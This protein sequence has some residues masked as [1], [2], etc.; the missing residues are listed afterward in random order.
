MHKRPRKEKLESLPKIRKRLFKIWSE[1]CRERANH[2]CEYCGR[3][4]GDLNENGKPLVKVDAHHLQSRKIS[5][6]PLK[7]DLR[8]SVCV[9]PLHH[10]FSCN[11]S[12]HKSPIITIAWLIKNHP[13]RFNYVLEHYND[14]V[15]LDNRNILG[16]IEK[17]LNNN[18]PLN[19][20]KLKEIEKNYP[21]K[22][23]EIKINSLFEEEKEKK[24]SSSK[25][26]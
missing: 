1:K 13:E 9:C 18:E 22:S 23:P 4:K 11:E 10:K 26:T 2:K 3:G 8:N 15:D 25:S 20:D 5:G 21:R 7:W 17:C 6:N 16:E 12:F 19:I 14:T 24:E